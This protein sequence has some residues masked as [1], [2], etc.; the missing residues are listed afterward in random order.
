MNCDSVMDTNGVGW[1]PCAM[2]AAAAQAL[3]II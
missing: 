3:N 2:R 1:T